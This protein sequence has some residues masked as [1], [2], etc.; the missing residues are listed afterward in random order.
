VDAS[1]RGTGELVAEAGGPIAAAGIVGRCDLLDG[2]GG[3][4]HEVE[5]HLVAL[6]EAQARA[7]EEAAQ[8]LSDVGALLEIARPDD[9]GCALDR[10][11]ELVLGEGEDRRLH[12]HQHQDEERQD[13][14]GEFDRGNAVDVPNEPRPQ[15]I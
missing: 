6:I 8:L 5:S 12:D 3:A 4:A 2:E 10:D 13:D 14:E 9:P 7:A 15:S 11:V 1:P